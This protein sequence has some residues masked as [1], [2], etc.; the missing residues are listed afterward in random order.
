MAADTPANQAEHSERTREADDLL[1]AVW[2]ST[3]D[4]GPFKGLLE[5]PALR[6]LIPCDLH[7]ATVLD[8]GCGPGAQ[9]AGLRHLAEGRRRGDPALLAPAAGGIHWLSTGC[10]CSR[11]G[12]ADFAAS[13]RPGPVPGAHKQAAR[14]HG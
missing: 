11:E 10:G 1:A 7:G 4:D 6:A 3:T 12:H 13:L 9:R 5:R 14:R 8:A 2:S